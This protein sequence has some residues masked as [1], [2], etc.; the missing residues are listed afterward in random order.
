MAMARPRR[1]RLAI[2]PTTARRFARKCRAVTTHGLDGLTA[3]SA[4]ST[5]SATSASS[6]PCIVQDHLRHLAD[7]RD[8]LLGIL[9][10]EQ[11]ANVEVQRAAEQV[12]RAR[13]HV[14]AVGDVPLIVC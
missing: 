7:G 14:L 8:D 1:A 12:Q 10:G 3:D 6:W 2:T 5:V 13:T 11:G 9:V 4:S